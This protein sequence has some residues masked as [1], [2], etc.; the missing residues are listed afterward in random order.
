MSDAMDDKSAQIRMGR[1]VAE[2]EKLAAECYK[3][4]REAEKLEMDRALAPVIAIGGLAVGALGLLLAI[5][6]H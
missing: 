1:D 3:L 2:S 6:K 5:L 4:L